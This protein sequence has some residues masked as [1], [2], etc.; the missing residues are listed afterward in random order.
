MAVPGNQDF[1][2]VRFPEVEDVSN[3][4][5]EQTLEPLCSYVNNDETQLISRERILSGNYEVYR[6]KNV[7]PA[8]MDVKWITEPGG[9]TLNFEVSDVRMV[10]IGSNNELLECRC[11][12][13][14]SSSDE[15]NDSVTKIQEVEADSHG[16]Q[17]DLTFKF[18]GKPGSTMIDSPAMLSMPVIAKRGCLN[19]SRY[20]LLIAELKELQDRGDFEGH[21]RKI[22]KQLAI[23]SPED[24]DMQ[25]SLQIER[26]VALYM[27]NNVQGA[28]KI[29]KFVLT[30]KQQLKNPEI[31]TGRAL[32]LLTSIYK[33]EK[34]FGKAM[35][36]VKRST[37]ALEYQDSPVDKAELYQS[38]GG[39][40]G[41]VLTVRRPDPT[42][43]RLTREEAYNSY[44]IAFDFATDPADREYINVKMAA[45]LLGES[46][47]Q[48]VKSCKEDIVKAKRHLDFIEFGAAADNMAVGT[49]IKLLL[50]RSDQYLYEGNVA[51]AMEKAQ[52][53]RMELTKIYDGFE[54]QRVSAK[55]Q[56]HLLSEILSQEYGIS[57]NSEVCLSN[58]DLAGSER[59]ESESD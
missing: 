10:L 50:Y 52:E 54:R 18:K 1:R 36:C 17:A 15:E 37:T 47:F 30:L 9:K 31:L 24:A 59:S 27:Q 39:L 35:E 56:I 49:K 32:N 5:A 51:M 12:N 14:Y 6:H 53:A 22:Q 46:H 48:K 7:A 33:N 2:H 38:Y 23:R 44:K 11:E 20:V 45:L 13:C 55:K 19:S 41:S 8:N 4:I 26:A 25:A 16:T 43:S 28:K 57:Q 34:K 40:I 29:A 42:R 3:G 21:E 58:G